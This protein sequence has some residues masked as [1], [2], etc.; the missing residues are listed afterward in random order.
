M[1]TKLS[2]IAAAA[3][4]NAGAA[5][6]VEYER[7]IITPPNG[8]VI[9]LYRPLHKTTTVALYSPDRMRTTRDSGTKDRG[10]EFRSTQVGNSGQVSYHLPEK[11]R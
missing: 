8:Q 10:T 3:L 7:Q 4:F 9:I 5:Y 1:K 6:A 11:Q 2:L